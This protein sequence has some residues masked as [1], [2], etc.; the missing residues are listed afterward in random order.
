MV[1][2]SALVTAEAAHAVALSVSAVHQRCSAC[3]AGLDAFAALFAVASGQCD[4][5]I[6]A[7]GGAASLALAGIQRLRVTTVASEAAGGAE[8]NYLSVDVAAAEAAAAGVTAA[9]AAAD[10]AGKDCHAVER[11]LAGSESLLVAGC[12]H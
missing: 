6:V 9:P 4:A 1:Q 12:F 5:H 7:D 3:G 2:E 11:V 10:Y 8:G